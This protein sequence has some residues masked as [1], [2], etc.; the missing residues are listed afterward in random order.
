MKFSHFIIRNLWFILIVV[1]PTFGAT[2]Y[3]TAIASDIYLSEAKY[4]VRSPNRTQ[5]S[6][7]SSVLQGSGL[8]KAQDDTYAVNDFLQSRDAVKAIQASNIDLRQI[9]G[10]PDTD[11]FARYPNILFD[12]SDE[13]LYK[14]YLKRVVVALDNSTGITTLSVKAFRPEDA[15]IVAAAALV[16]GESLINQLSARAQENA[17]R[18]AQNEVRNA[19][20]RVKAAEKSL[21]DYREREI[22]IDPTKQSVLLIEGIAKLQAELSMANAQLSQVLQSSPNSPLVPTLR[23]TVRALEEEIIRERAKVAGA[24]GAMA[25]KIADYQ[26]LILEQEFASKALASATAS[27]ETARMEA[28]RQH[29]YL[30]RVVEPNAPDVG[31]YPKRIVSIAIVL[32]SG[33]VLYFMLWLLL[34]GVRDHANR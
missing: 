23:A 8:V 16:A 31:L 10:R 4:I 2:V 14:Y 21:L 11:Y 19:E 26:L 32:I 15:R 29:F 34:L 30:E 3:Y 5:L 17:L 25:Q 33:L 28:Q 13:G 22:I 9:Y 12:T 24:S 20:E 27:L 6:A 18:D 1:L 7:L